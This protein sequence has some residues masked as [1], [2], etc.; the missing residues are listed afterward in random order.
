[1]RQRRSVRMGVAA[2]GVLALITVGSVRSAPTEAAWT[3]PEYAKNNSITAAT[4]PA[5][6]IT[7]CQAGSVLGLLITSISF[8]WTSTE[9]LA[10]QRHF[11]ND[12]PGTLTPTVSGPVNGVYTYSVTYSQALL[13]TVLSLLASQVRISVATVAGTNWS[14][15]RTNWVARKI[16]LGTEC[17]SS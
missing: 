13:E 16:L 7:F 6:N 10:A 4:L 1:M 5:P 17:V 8:R 2:I 3:E 11:L 12:I 9:P 15:S 14:S